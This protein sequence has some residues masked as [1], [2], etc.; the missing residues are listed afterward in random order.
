MPQFIEHDIEDAFTQPN[1]VALVDAFTGEPGEDEDAN[2]FTAQD[3]SGVILVVALHALTQGDTAVFQPVFPVRVPASQV[4]LLEYPVHKR[5]LAGEVSIEQ[6]L[7][8]PDFFGEFA[9]A[10][11][12][13]MGG[14]I[15]NGLFD[16]LSFAFFRGQATPDAFLF[17]SVRTGDG[18]VARTYGSGFRHCKSSLRTAQYKSLF[19]T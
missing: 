2:P 5:F 19:I 18:G 8:D 10:G 15:P 13:A 4:N 11:R 9:R 17:L 7:R 6:G 12:K 14:E 16:D 1:Q 3:E